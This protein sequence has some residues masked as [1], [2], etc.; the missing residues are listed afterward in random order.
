[1]TC[2]DS[3]IHDNLVNS[4]EER[5][6]SYLLMPLT[7]DHS[8]GTFEIDRRTGSLVVARQ[9]DREI[10]DEYRLEV[11]ALDT[12]ATNNPQSSAVTVKIEIVDVNDNAPQWPQDPVNIEISEVTPIGMTVYNFTAI[13]AD[14]GLN[15]EL[16][17]HITSSL[18]PAKNIFKLD[19]LT[20][21]LTL[22][23]TLDY[24]TLKEYWLI[25]EATDLASNVS[26]RITTSAT[27]HISVIDANDNVPTFV[28]ANK[29]SIS[30][31]MVSG[32]L[33]QALAV[34]GDSGEN[35]RISYY[36]SSGNDH[37]YF[38]MEYD[39]GKLTLSKKYSSDISRVRLG[40][41]KLNLTASDHGIP[42]PRQSHMTLLLNLQESTNVPPRFTDSFY[43]A[44]ISEDI[45]PGSFVTRLNAKS[46]RGNSGKYTKPMFCVYISCTG[47]LLTRFLSLISGN[48]TYQIPSGVA[49]DQFVIDERLGTITV[50]SRIDREQRD[51]YFFPVYVTDSSTFQSTSNFDVATVSISILDVN[52]NPPTFKTGS[53]YPLAVPENNEPEVIHTVAATDKDI[54][55]NGVITYS[56]TSGNNGNKFS[57]DSTTGKLTA[58]TLDRE[59]QAKY[60]LTITAFDHGSPVALQG[61]CNIT[62]I[63]EDQNDNDPVFDTGHYSAAIPEDA[64]I[65]TS[66]IKVRATDADLG[67]NK[68]IVYSLANESQGLF[69]IDNKTG[70]IFTTG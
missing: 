6:I 59:T 33:Y 21:S 19:P 37:A 62:I 9:L 17:F 52:D 14:A 57:I 45:R 50:K 5:Q 60:H 41:Y 65:D 39:T 64:L 31:S 18:P 20:G 30:L 44:N 46:S 15:G 40:Q 23:S 42:F 22:T 69:R 53:C 26:E 25:V 27:V 66:V 48:L 35:G 56:I 67:F 8:P 49:E 24:E 32:S 12:S 29:A 70:I 61:S 51:T 28:S 34:D 54:G 4:D 3:D 68:R 10:Q 43:R 13:D 11:R 55:A 63:V 36:I 1:M 7:T 58:R 16:N 47:P 38:S 2:Y